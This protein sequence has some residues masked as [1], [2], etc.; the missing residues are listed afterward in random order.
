M[1]FYRPDSDL[2]Q[3][4]HAV[5]D[6]LKATRPGLEEQLS[7]TWLL[8]DSSPSIWP[9]AWSPKMCG[10]CRF[11]ALRTAV[12]SSATRQCGETGLCHGH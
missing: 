1:A 5:L 11:A 2:T 8:Y 3:A 7:I 6:D 10:R 4:L 9:Q 12:I